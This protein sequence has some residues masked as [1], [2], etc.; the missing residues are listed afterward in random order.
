MTFLKHSHVLPLVNFLL[1]RVSHLIK[2]PLQVVSSCRLQGLLSVGPQS[3]EAQTVT[4]R[5]AALGRELCAYQR[6]G[7]PKR[8]WPAP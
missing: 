6:L 2:L 5:P 8:S 4:A 3:A 7:T 1:Q